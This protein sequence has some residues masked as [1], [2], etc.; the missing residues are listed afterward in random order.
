MHQQYVRDQEA[1]GEDQGTNPALVTW[2]D[3]TE[4]LKESNRAQAG[5]IGVKLAAVGCDLS[6]LV[7]WKPDRFGFQPEEIE[8][9]AKMEHERFVQERTRAGW[10]HGPKDTERKRTPHL[11]PWIELAPEVQDLDRLFIRELPQ[12]LARAGFQIV[13]VDRSRLSRAE[14]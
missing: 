9:L 1:K 6:P 11:V 14:K 10:V 5:H 13:R 12:S 7:D 2:E 4:S 8:K 3:L